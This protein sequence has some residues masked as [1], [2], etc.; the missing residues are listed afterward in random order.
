MRNKGKD[1]QNENIEELF[2]H[3]HPN[4][5]LLKLSI[6]PHPFWFSLYLF[7]SP[8]FMFFWPIIILE[9]SALSYLYRSH[10]YP[11]ERCICNHIFIYTILNLIVWNLRNEKLLLI[12]NIVI[13][14]IYFERSYGNSE[15]DLHVNIFLNFSITISKI[16]FFKRTSILCIRIN[17][18]IQI[19]FVKKNDRMKKKI[20]IHLCRS[21]FANKI[22]KRKILIHWTSKWY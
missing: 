19:L 11:I 12:F 5:S 13:S 22:L 16:F 2:R 4:L 1:G 21:L 9:F 15:F 8:L 3:H 20:M 14:T 10:S 18:R 17:Q 6:L 7:F